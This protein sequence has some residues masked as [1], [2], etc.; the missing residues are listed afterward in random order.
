MISSTSF[1]DILLGDF[2]TK[3]RNTK[4]CKT[5]LQ[6]VPFALSQRFFEWSAQ[7]ALITDTVD[8]WNPNNHL[9]CMKPYKWWD[10]LPYQLMQ[11]FSHQQYPWVSPF[12]SPLHEK[13]RRSRSKPLP[14]PNLALVKRTPAMDMS[15][16]QNGTYHMVDVQL[17]QFHYQQHVYIYI[18]ILWIQLYTSRFDD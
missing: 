13:S 10:K 16:F 1:S 7:S 6:H 18:Y 2:N 14:F 5:S 11:D 3:K 17:S 8:G 12:R 15:L 9:T 4:L